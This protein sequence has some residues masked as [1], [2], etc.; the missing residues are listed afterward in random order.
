MYLTGR[1][2][3]GSEVNIYIIVQLQLDV[4]RFVGLSVRMNTYNSGTIQ[5]KTFKFDD[6]MFDY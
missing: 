2:E 4:V 5:A 6:N 3:I 1:R